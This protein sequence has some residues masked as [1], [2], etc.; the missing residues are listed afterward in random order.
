MNEFDSGAKGSGE[1][2]ASGAVVS[3]RRVL[4]ALGTAGLAAGIGGVA[5]VV[6]SRLG[7]GSADD[8]TGV[9]GKGGAGGPDLGL[10]TAGLDVRGAAGIYDAASFG[11]RGDGKTDD[12]AALQ[13]A[14][15][16]CAK[17]GGI[18][19]IPAGR[20]VCTDTLILRSGVT[21]RG[22]GLDQWVPSAQNIV[23]QDVRGTHLVFTGE[24]PKKHSLYGVTNMSAGGGV[25]DNPES[26]GSPYE[27]MNFYEADAADNNPAT[28]RKFSV[29]VM[30]ENAA[31]CGIGGLRI[32]HSFRGIEGFNS[33]SDAGSGDEWDIGLWVK[34]SSQGRYER[35]QTVG[36]WRMYGVLVT[37]M[38]ESAKGNDV[39]TA[40][41]N[42][43]DQCVMSGKVGLGFRSGDVYRCVGVSGD[44]VQLSWSTSNPFPADGGKFRVSSDTYS[45]SST[46]RV[47]EGVL[48]LRGVSPSPAKGGVKAGN[49]I[50]TS[51]SN[52][53][54]AG[55]IVS[56]CYI[57]GFDHSSGVV[58][59]DPSLS[60]PFRTPSCCLEISGE[61]VRG[62]NFI[63]CTIQSREEVLMHLHDARDV[64]FFGCYFES[65]TARSKIG[66]SFNAPAGGRMIASPFVGN[67]KAPAPAGETNG[68]VFARCTGTDSV[69][70]RQP[71]FKRTGKTRFNA[72]SGLFTPRGFIDD[73]LTGGQIEGQMPVR[74]PKNKPLVVY[75]D[76]GNKLATFGYNEAGE[77]DL[78]SGGG[79]VRL[80]ANTA[81]R[82]LLTESDIRAYG[83]VVPDADRILDLG[84]SD[85]R[86]NDVYAAGGVITTSDARAKDEIRPLAAGLGL[87]LVGKLRPVL[88]KYKNFVPSTSSI[89]HGEEG[90][91]GNIDGMAKADNIDKSAEAGNPGK[92]DNSST[93]DKSD[94]PG[95]ADVSAAAVR[96]D[97]FGLIA[98]EVKTAFNDLGFDA[99]AYVYDE[100]TDQHALRYSEFVPV[101]IKA[102]QEL[103]EE[104]TRLKATLQV[105]HDESEEV[106]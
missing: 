42:H 8:M 72:D 105:Q 83:P 11:A 84:A 27:L 76:N 50:R 99:G 51:A 52:F 62:L 96:R 77:L 92:A 46:A 26:P 85:R 102:V 43:W 53:G 73:S 71:L 4:A 87:N 79:S 65:K 21:V 81:T 22:V 66:S 93:A 34:N 91:S 6:A 36:Y 57:A 82:L 31:N 94:V 37:S 25:R 63:H 98:Q 61:P 106:S 88:Y 1:S 74:L 23:K 86:W 59:T 19:W 44:A 41:S 7:P 3:R 103:Q 18:V 2:A 48:D 55:T 28:Q 100:R 69:I 20:Y 24:G 35:L 75:D 39:P 14:F 90:E 95:V 9:A 12:T 32:T 101:L 15:D 70:C 17:R 80:R 5:G 45:Y 64:E 40:E 67:S 58:C 97:H 54:F 10:G 13:A 33:A 104:V 38:N 56:D 89:E 78:R 47:E 16:A 29:A 68:L 49:E 30:V 60:V